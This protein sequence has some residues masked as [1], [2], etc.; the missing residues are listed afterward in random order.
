MLILRTLQLE[1]RHGVAIADRIAQIT[2]GTF[3][4]KPG[5]LFPALQRLEQ[6]GWIKGTWGQSPEGRRVRTYALTAAGKK[7]L[8]A[9]R[10]N[11]QRV[12]EAVGQ[13]LEGA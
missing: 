8:T 4:V 5:S 3:Q 2:S 6:D 13:V 1:A 9:E 12:A 7:Q 10:A 11:W